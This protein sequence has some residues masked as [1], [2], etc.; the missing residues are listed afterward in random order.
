MHSMK[1]FLLGILCF[2]L[3]LAHAQAQVKVASLH[4]LLS[5]MAQ[6][7]GGEHVEVVDLFPKNGELHAFQP[8]ASDIARAAGAKL[9]LACGKDLEPYMRDLQQS[10]P[11]GTGILSLGNAIPD[12]FLPGST[13]PDPH[14]WSTPGNMKRASRAMLRA[15]VALAPEHREALLSGQR[16]Y[17]IEMD[18]LTREAR[19]AFSRIAQ[20]QRIL[21][22]SHAATAHF[23]K[24]FGF[25]AIAIHGIAHESEGDTASMAHLLKELRAKQVTCLFYDINESPRAMQTLADQIGA[26]LRPIILDGIAPGYESYASIFRANVSNISIGLA[27]GN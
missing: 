22:T 27:P 26:G 19:L 23:C 1:S 10:L 7:I 8:S 12:V 2:L 4:P 24:E 13:R 16:A 14:W 6:C 25:T 5:E 17:A 3:C 21:T 18:T 11:E 9:I 15:L 20:E